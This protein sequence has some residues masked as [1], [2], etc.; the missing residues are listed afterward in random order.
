MADGR[1]LRFDGYLYARRNNLSERPVILDCSCGHRTFQGQ[2]F[3]MAA[4]FMLQRGRIKEGV[5]G[6]T[7][8]GWRRFRSS[9]CNCHQPIP[10]EYRHGSFYE[11]WDQ[12]F[13]SDCAKA[14]TLSNGCTRQPLMGHTCTKS[15]ESL[16]DPSL[17]FPLPHTILI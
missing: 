5:R 4:M 2:A 12:S 13:S 17:P 10:S 8:Q 16:P 1:A 7:S 14:R 9:S 3:L 11:R 6:K 15:A